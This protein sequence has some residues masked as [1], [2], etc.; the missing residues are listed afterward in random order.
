MALMR[1]LVLTEHK[2]SVGSEQ[3]RLQTIVIMH[4]VGL[5]IKPCES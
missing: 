4:F 1:A 3:A 2:V 5:D